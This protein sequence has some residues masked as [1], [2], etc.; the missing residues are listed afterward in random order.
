MLVQEDTGTREEIQGGDMEA[1]ENREAGSA[2]SRG[3]PGNLDVGR[4]H[5]GQ[6]RETRHRIQLGKNG[7]IRLRRVAI[8]TI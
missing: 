7:R 2:G 4:R 5:E 1:G 6:N 8:K 3:N